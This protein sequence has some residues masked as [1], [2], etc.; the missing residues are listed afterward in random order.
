MATST[1]SF[2][3]CKLRKALCLK[4]LVEPVVLLNWNLGP[5]LPE[6]SAA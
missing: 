6:S 5:C 4:V 2:I 1:L 3:A